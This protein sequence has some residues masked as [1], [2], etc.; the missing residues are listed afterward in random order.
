MT[1]IRPTRGT[2]QPAST[3]WVGL[4]AHMT[5]IRPTGDLAQEL[6]MITALGFSPGAPIG[7]LPGSGGRITSKTAGA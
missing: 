4:P 2:D 5:E 1:E 3:R 6:A 7:Y